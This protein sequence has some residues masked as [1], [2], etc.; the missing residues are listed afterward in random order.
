ML[1]KKDSE[2]LF[3]MNYEVHCRPVVPGMGMQFEYF[4]GKFR[5]SLM[6]T[7]RIPTL[8]IKPLH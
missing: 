2:I 4:E 8:R 1:E 3:I 5:I 6:K 7:K